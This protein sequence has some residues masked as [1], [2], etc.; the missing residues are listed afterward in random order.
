VKHHEAVLAKLRKAKG[1]VSARD[2]KIVPP[3]RAR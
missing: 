3:K 1:P 2:G